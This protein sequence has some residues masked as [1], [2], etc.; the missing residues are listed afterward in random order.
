MS[1]SEFSD[2]ASK[3]KLV[4]KTKNTIVDIA[5]LTSE[6]EITK[7]RG[8]ALSNEEYLPGLNAIAAP[9]HRH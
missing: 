2:F 3:T 1:E 7:K 8:Y 4:A 5:D 6:L 9:L